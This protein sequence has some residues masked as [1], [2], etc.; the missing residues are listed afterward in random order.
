[1]IQ[2]L[3]LAAGGQ[4]GVGPSDAVRLWAQACRCL[5]AIS[6]CLHCTHPPSPCAASPCGFGKGVP[7]SGR[8]SH[9]F[10]GWQLI[11]DTWLEGGEDVP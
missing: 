8:Y 1:M 6:T 5:V 7:L 10:Q 4:A 3:T 9:E 2:V 11:K